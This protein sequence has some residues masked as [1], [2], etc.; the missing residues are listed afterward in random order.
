MANTPVHS[1][2]LAVGVRSALQEI[3]KKDR[4]STS[5]MISRALEDYIETRGYMVCPGDCC[6]SGIMGEDKDGEPQ[7]C[8]TCNGLGYVPHKGKRK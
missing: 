4:R 8:D 1:V 2:R 6:G 7:E 3:A 5:N